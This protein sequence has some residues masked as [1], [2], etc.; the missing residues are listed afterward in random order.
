MKLKGLTIIECIL[1]ISVTS[2]SFIDS[3][4]MIPI[5]D[6]THKIINL[7]IEAFCRMQLYLFF[8]LFNKALAAL[9]LSVQMTLHLFKLILL[10]NALYGGESPCVVSILANNVIG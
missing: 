9:S 5:C 10:K 8:L 1:S 6:G 4:P 3:F 2:G 7:S